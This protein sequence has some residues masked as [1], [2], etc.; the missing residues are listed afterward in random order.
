MMQAY[1]FLLALAVAGPAAAETPTG[2]ACRFA[3]FK[4]IA[5]GEWSVIRTTRESDGTL[6]TTNRPFKARIPRAGVIEISDADGKFYLRMIQTD[7]GY[8]YEEPDGGGAVEGG[9]IRVTSCSAPDANGTQTIV[10]V[11]AEAGGDPSAPSRVD[12]TLTV[13][14]AGPDSLTMTGSLRPLGSS[15]PYRWATTMTLLKTH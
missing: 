15:S 11:G 12:D 3:A 2:G 4:R 6:V 5:E 7:T 10:E 8:R 14:T 13:V 9:D 1:L